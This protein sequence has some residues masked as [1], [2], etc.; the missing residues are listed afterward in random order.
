LLYFFGV[1]QNEVTISFC[2]SEARKK[3]DSRR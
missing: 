2:K 1:V 3:T